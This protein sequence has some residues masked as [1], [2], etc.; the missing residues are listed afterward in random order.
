MAGWGGGLGDG[1]GGA[2]GGVGGAGGGVG[3][4]GGGGGGG[5]VAGGGG[6]GFPGAHMLRRCS[7]S[8]EDN[9]GAH[10]APIIAAASRLED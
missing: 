4:R 5:G 2:G 6:G 7:W 3:S 9:D 1:V 10:S 8:R